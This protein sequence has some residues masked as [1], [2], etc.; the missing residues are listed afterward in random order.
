LPTQ[1]ASTSS[2]TARPATLAYAGAP[3][4]RG[5]GAAGVIWKLLA[6]FVGLAVVVAFFYY[7]SPDRFLSWLN[8]KI[9]A[10]QTVYIALPA[11][12]MAFIMIGGGIDLSVGSVIA[13]CGVVAALMI[14]HGVGFDPAITAVVA[15]VLVGGL[16]GL[17]NGLLI[18][19][20]RIIPFVVTLGMLGIARGLAKYLANNQP[21]RIEVLPPALDGLTQPIRSMRWWDFAP[22]VWMMLGLAILAGILLNLTRFGRRTFALG[23]NEMAA[24]YSGIRINPQ[25]WMLYTFGGLLT[26]L[27]GVLMFCNLTQGDPTVAEGIELQVI[28]AVVIGGGSLLGGEGSILGTM[29]GAFML[30]FL[31]NGCTLARYPNYVQQIVIGLIIILAVALDYFRR[32]TPH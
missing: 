18:T 11:I 3:A 15:G 31:V 25:K 10:A 1:T 19:S 27:S 2:N 24:Q 23:A 6:P 12:G 8:L 9:V 28:A 16:I 13:L 4:R 17:I 30:T 5:A 29:V 22:S 32:R 14:Q 21:I 7:K 20:L 26:G